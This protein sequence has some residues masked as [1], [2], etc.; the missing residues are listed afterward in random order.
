MGKVNIIV[1]HSLHVILIFSKGT[2]FKK[3]VLHTLGTEPLIRNVTLNANICQTEVHKKEEEDDE[4]IVC[5]NALQAEVLRVTGA[6]YFFI[7]P[8]N[9]FAR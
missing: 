8:F 7:S 3:H 2:V 6:K 9:V 1:Y 4:G 5:I